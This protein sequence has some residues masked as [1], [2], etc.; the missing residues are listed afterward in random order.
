MVSIGRSEAG[1]RCRHL[2]YAAFLLF[3][4][5]LNARPAQAQQDGFAFCK[6][7][8]P[9]SSYYVAGEPV[10]FTDLFPVTP[11]S[12]D[13]KTAFQDF[14]KQ[15]Y[16]WTKKTVS[17]AIG[18]TKEGAEKSYNES[19]KAAGDKAVRTGWTIADVRASAPPRN[20]HQ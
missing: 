4:I 10:Y 5:G 20:P 17:C 18:F 3:L 14:L 12:P 19:L 15:K 9:G 11:S 13:Y 6:T 16:G 2:L 1:I 7:F 8:A